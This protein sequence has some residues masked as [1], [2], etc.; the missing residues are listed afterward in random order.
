MA[1]LQPASYLIGHV[2]PVLTLDNQD[3]MLAS[4]SEDKTCRIWDIRADKVHKA[5]TGFKSAVSTT[6]FTPA[7]AHT[8]Y[9]GSGNTIYTYD[10]RMESLILDITQSTKTYDGAE[11]EINQIQVNYRA[12]YLAAC[13][14]TGDVRVLDL[15][16][17]KWMRQFERK[18]ENIAMT[19]QFVPKKE[20]QALSGGMDKLVVAWDFYK[21]RATQLIDTD[22]PQPEGVQSK[23]LFNPPFVHSLAVH[24]SGTR[25]AI[26]LGD[27]TV[28]FLHTAA[29]LP[30]AS[31]LSEGGIIASKSM[32]SSKKN[33]KKTA[34]GGDKGGEGW[35]LGGRL[36]EAHASPI[37]TIV[38]AGFNS[39]WLVTSANN[40]TIAIWDDQ[41]SR[42]ESVQRQQLLQQL[43][44]QQEP[45]Q[46]LPYG[47][48]LQPL[49]EFKTRDVFERVN[50]ISTS[51]SEGKNL[52]IAGTH[53]RIGE[54][55]LQGRIAV[56]RL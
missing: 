2:A 29:D 15:K 27:G 46:P 54:K 7:D 45:Q 47:R 19:V 10:L 28:Q 25:A 13:D 22:T 18:H 52:F 41:S 26:G 9:V 6:A 55:R 4:G 38:Y 49:Q 8:I 23:Q 40:G 17:H 12:T 56:Y 1:Q 36:V 20:L 50:C 24:P 14:D 53:P 37:A 30:T 11:D 39:E 43:M 5:L 42:Y 44:K 34:S 32:A 48:P 35:L 31:S 16:S 51:K 3:W 33:K 21:G